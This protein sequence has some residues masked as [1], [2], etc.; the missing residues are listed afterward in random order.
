[1]E[2]NNGLMEYYLQ[3]VSHKSNNVQVA[4]CLQAVSRFWAA[5]PEAYGNMPLG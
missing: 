5:T 1:M 4:S 2:W 3:V